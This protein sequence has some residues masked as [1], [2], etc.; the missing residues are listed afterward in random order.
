MKK[1]LIVLICFTITIA[2]L[3]SLGSKEEKSGDYKIGLCNY[4]DDASLNQICESI[5]E[6]IKE[7]EKEKGISITI[8]YD[9]C[10]ADANVLSQ[11]IANFIAQDVD[12]MIGVA[13]PVALAMQAATEDNE[14]PVIFSAVSDP[15]SVSLVDSLEHPG[16]NVSGTSDYLDTNS[17]LSLMFAL[18][19]EIKKVG[20]LYDIGQDS[21]TTAINTARSILKEKGIEIVEK[22]GTNV[23]EIKLALSSLVA[24]KV[25][26]IFTPCD[27]TV[28][29]SE[30]SIYEEMKEN[31]ILHFTGADS[32][33]LNGAFLGYGVDYIALGRETANMA[34]EVLV[35]GKDIS[36]LPVRTFDNGTATINREILQAFGYTEKELSDILSPYCTSVVF[37]DTAESF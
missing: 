22:T 1:A 6:R 35:D 31:G 19:P 21:S 12:L 20:L 27:N 30:L 36:S 32:F 15:L 23:D 13:T 34:V 10:N 16:S 2:S 26:A 9:N 5:E 29:T 33:A 11:I 28:M 25:E 17:I 37:I 24:E 4:V 7:I 14:I 3:F 18:K 8:Y